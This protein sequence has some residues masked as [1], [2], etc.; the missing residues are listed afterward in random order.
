METPTLLTPRSGRSRFSKALPAP[1]PFLGGDT[2]TIASRQLPAL[3]D[4]STTMAFPPRTDSAGARYMAKPLN[5]PLPALPSL[6][7]EPEA[8][9]PVKAIPRKAV[10]I[11]SPPSAQPTT[12]PAKLKRLSSISSLLSA[13]SH[14]T[15]DSV[16]RSS[17][18]SSVTKDSAPSFSPEQE[19]MDIK[20]KEFTDS[21]AA[22]SINPYAESASPER[23]PMERDRLPPPPPLKNLNRPTTPR[24]GLPATPRSARPVAPPNEA[25]AT[26][27]PVSLTNDA[28]QKREIWRRRAS[29]KSDRSLAVAGLKLA[30]S[31]GST[32]ATAAPT[33]PTA[34]IAGPLLLPLQ[35][36]SIP[37]KS[38]LSPRPPNISNGLPGRDI[39]PRTPR[40]NA[41]AEMTRPAPSLEPISTRRPEETTEFSQK[42]DNG[43]VAPLMKDPPTPE[44]SPT[45][46]QQ[47]IKLEPVQSPGAV[48]P[49]SSPEPSL[50]DTTKPVSRRP[51]GARTQDQLQP[52]PDPSQLRGQPSTTSLRSPTSALPPRPSAGHATQPN[53]ANQQSNMEEEKPSA[54]PPMDGSV[55]PVAMNEENAFNWPEPEPLS[56]EQQ[57][58]V[59]A[60][61][62]RFPRE[63]QFIATENG[64]WPA[65]PLTVTHY[66]CLANHR[67]WHRVRNTNY[68]V[69]CMTC[70]AADKQW[71]S[72]CRSCSIRVCSGCA[73]QLR[74]KNL[75]D[76]DVDGLRKGKQSVASPT[77]GVMN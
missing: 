37:D 3:P 19:S 60:A 4:M 5:S 23:A 27:S 70:H 34:P 59:N 47:Q 67:G 71:R 10:P 25:D 46:S 9:R 66:K 45:S 43:P 20:R 40:P 76:L 63:F 26:S 52:G 38:G 35:N 12:T 54:I 13:Y 7:S 48:S 41:N 16:Q 57:D 1:P 15:S 51:V 24:I 22:Y 30:D 42:P 64:V 32:A 31:H 53:K 65:A 29:S 17:H 73:D 50:R 11:S 77:G 6:P 62:S 56:Q 44:Y 39:K 2:S 68:P 74:G 36:N 75:A 72:V 55:P 33:A 14:S 58:R 21:L 69:Q 8:P 49:L 18:D 61:I 28:P